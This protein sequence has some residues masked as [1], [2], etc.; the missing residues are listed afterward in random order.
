MCFL[1]A[2]SMAFALPATKTIGVWQLM[3]NSFP[4]VTVVGSGMMSQKAPAV[5]K[6]VIVSI[7]LKNNTKQNQS[8]S[9]MLESPQ[10]VLK[11]GTMVESDIAT[12][13]MFLSSKPAD[14]AIPAGLK[15]NTE[16]LFEV[17]KSAKNMRFYIDFSTGLRC[18]LT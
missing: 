13:M 9:S 3:V 2:G 16:F 10:L 7:T 5:S 17:P 12:G 4:E 6:Y 15:K 14:G 11:D 1:L 8:F 18:F